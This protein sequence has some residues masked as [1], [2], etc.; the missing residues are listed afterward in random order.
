MKPDC[1]TL[2]LAMPGWDGLTTLENIMTKYPVPVTILSAHSKKD[3]D[4]T[5]KCLN[6]GAVG[7]VLKPSGE[8]SLDIKEV[9]HELLE[10]VKAA[11]RVSPTRIKSLIRRKPR[12]PG[13]KLIAVDRIIV[14][15]A[16][17]G[18]PQTL[19]T[20]LFSLSINLPVPV[21]I[22]QHMPNKFFTESLA[23]HLNKAG[24]LEVKVADNG[25]ALRPGKVYLAP[26]GFQTRIV[27]DIRRPA[28][29][30]V[31]EDKPDA[32]S[33][34]IDMTMKSVAEIYDGNTIG[35]ILSGMG[36]DGREG[37]KAIKE[38]GGRTIVQDESS[39]I[40]G[41]PKAVIDEG[42]ADKVLPAGKIADAIVE[43]VNTDIKTNNQDTRNNN[44][45][46]TKFQ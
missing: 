6:A 37:M 35:I 32:L 27:A 14:I 34:S 10:Q 20:I 7:F 13:R 43:Y 12:R 33:P 2:D 39:L 29:I 1:I 18:G 38:S 23:E 44:Q 40:F 25:E 9:K 31:T 19:E 8:L 36:Y 4:I 16:S 30:R 41:M 21:I 45:I 11:S 46:I 22:V 3:A 15:G 26:G 42:Y 24:D 5:I 17:T 28:Y